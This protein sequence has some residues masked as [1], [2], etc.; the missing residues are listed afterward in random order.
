MFGESFMGPI[1]VPAA[2]P[3]S[4]SPD[5]PATETRP[6]PP[7][8]AESVVH[9]GVAPAAQHPS[10][11]EQDQ[12]ERAHR[13][14]NALEEVQCCNRALP[15]AVDRAS[16]AATGEVLALLALTCLKEL[17]G[18]T[19]IRRVRIDRSTTVLITPPSATRTVAW[20]LPPATDAVTANRP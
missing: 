11:Q 3:A 2:S 12:A 4:G 6:Y 7:A 16:V 5:Q 8:A 17:D 20:A 18:T 1:P 19:S 14:E 10:D 15:A 9:P 13:N